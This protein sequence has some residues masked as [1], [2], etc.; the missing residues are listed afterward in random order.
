[1][2]QPISVQL[3]HFFTHPIFLAGIT[4]WLSAQFIKTL[5]DL[6]YG[7]IHSFTGLVEDLFWRTGGMPSNH[8]A[9][10]CSACT[11]IGFRNGV[12]S[13]IFMFSLIFFLVVIRDA[14]GVRRASG[15]QA[16][17]INE[18]GSELKEKGIIQDYKK[19]KEINGHT[20][21]QV[22]FGCVLGLLVGCAF[23]LL[24]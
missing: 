22:M 14:V 1:M 24:K 21:I 10:V 13:D 3:K 16:Q 15:N 17:K 9:L 6:I 23:S 8:S 7:R 5:L 20:P 4:S 18:I 11:T 2:L 19:T 12:D